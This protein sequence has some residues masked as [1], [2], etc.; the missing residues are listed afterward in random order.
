MFISEQYQVQ[1]TF[2]T[3]LSIASLVFSAQLILQR[4]TNVDLSTVT[5]D[6]LTKQCPEIP[7][8]YLTVNHRVLCSLSHYSLSLSRHSYQTCTRAI[9]SPVNSVLL[10]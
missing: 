9:E 5:L 10:P 8:P 4:L 3:I 2:Q 1:P 7:V 6:R